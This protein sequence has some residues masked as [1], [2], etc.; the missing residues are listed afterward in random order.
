MTLAADQDQHKACK[1]IN[2]RF[3]WSRRREDSRHAKKGI[4]G[5]SVGW[6]G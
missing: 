6:R 5:W 4:D 1:N 2:S 3:T